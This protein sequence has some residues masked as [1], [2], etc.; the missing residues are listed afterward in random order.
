M[1]RYKAPPAQ[2]MQKQGLVDLLGPLAAKYAINAAIPGG[3]FAADAA[4]AAVPALFNKG[5][6]AGPLGGGQTKEALKE[7]RSM[8]ALTQAEF[9]KAMAH[10]GYMNK[11]GK[12]AC[13]PLASVSYKSE[14]GEVWER[15]YHD[16]N[17]PKAGGPA[18]KEG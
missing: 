16:P 18:K 14:G 6:M 7:A 3:G 4:T 2:V 1:S 10:G 15:K 17:K 9:L 12:V 11:G 13:G 8:G 5:G